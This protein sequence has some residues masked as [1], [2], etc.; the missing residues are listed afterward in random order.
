MKKTYMIVFL[1]F[2]HYSIISFQ[3]FSQTAPGIQWA[4]CYGG[5]RNDLACFA[6]GLPDGNFIVAGRTS[7]YD[8]DVTIT[9]NYPGILVGTD[10]WLL[11]LDTAGGIIWQKCYGGTEND[12]ALDF[13]PA[14]DGGFILAGYS[15]SGD[16]DVSGNN[17]GSHDCWI[18]RLDSTGA[19]QWQQCLGG[20]S[21][22]AS[23]S[24]IQTS[25]N[26][27]M[28][29]GR[30]NSN[31]SDVT[32]N[33]GGVDFWAVELDTSGN[34]V[35]QKCYGGSG[36]DFGT[37]IAPAQDGGYIMAGSSQ[38]ADGDVSGNYGS[39]D[40]WIVK[41]DSIGG[42]QW[43]KKYGGSGPESA[44]DIRQ[45]PDGG[46]IFTGYTAS[47]DSDVTGNYGNNDVWVVRLDAAGGIV[48]QKCYG[49]TNNEEAYRIIQTPDAGFV[50]SGY[51][52]SGDSNVTGN[53]GSRD[54]WIFKVDSLGALIWEKCFGGSD[55]DNGFQISNTADGGFILCGSTES[56]DGDVT[57]NHDSTGIRSDLW[58]V[59]IGPDT[60]TGQPGLPSS[61]FRLQFYPNPL[62][63]QSTLAFENDNRERFLFT[64]CDLTGRVTETVS[65]T[66]HAIILAKGN[67]QPGIYLYQL[68]ST[69]TNE[70]RNGKMLIAD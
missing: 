67:K 54:F 42:I 38:S 33:H 51:T 35:W 12:Y 20:S 45:T 41:T 30:T 17:G 46:Y 6:A 37:S 16:G 11:K 4:K 22:D 13:K 28:A 56:N 44:N 61:L 5:S 63:T 36:H 21:E 15:D 70:R 53:H 34:M 32:G 50:I 27:F 49:G 47:N 40:C 48:W 66:D 1:G 65:T 60:I 3:S 57:G 68:T 25:N 55:Q 52:S 64:L 31:D 18:I 62:T 9:Y 58:V 10:Y 69:K 23:S 8:G 19:K 2:I 24:V 59:K 39:K 26:H 14:G 43:Q 29:L 7:S